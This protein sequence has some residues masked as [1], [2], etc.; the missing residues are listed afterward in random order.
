MIDGLADRAISEGKRAVKN[1]QQMVAHRDV[2]P[3]EV[4][5]A[6]N[7]LQSAV[8]ALK[9]L[10]EVSK[11]ISAHDL[12]SME[13][14]LIMLEEKGIVP[15]DGYQGIRKVLEEQ[16][17]L[18]ALQGLEIS[19]VQTSL[20]ETNVTFDIPMPMRVGRWLTDVGY[21]VFSA[22]FYSPVYHWFRVEDFHPNYTKLGVYQELI[23]EVKIETTH[24]KGFR[25]ITEVETREEVE[26]YRRI[27]RIDLDTDPW[28]MRINGNS[29]IPESL[30]IARGLS[31]LANQ[32]VNT[33]LVSEQPVSNAPLD[34]P[35]SLD[36]EL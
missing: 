15:D 5:Y 20:A 2:S 8:E 36:K 23:K 3:D 26:A 1:F 33:Y 29:N 16:R 34:Y 30:I 18:V 35:H 13:R 32:K 31:Q 17:R 12:Q 4:G 11:G 10:K 28:Q 27:C 24:R 6:V 7:G 19:A 9:A 21:T 14:L 25:V 22:R